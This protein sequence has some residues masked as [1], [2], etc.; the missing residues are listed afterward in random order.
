[1]SSSPDPWS[2]VRNIAGR[3]TDETRPPNRGADG[4]RAP[5]SAEPSFAEASLPKGEDAPD[6]VPA[7]DDGAISEQHLETATLQPAR[8]AEPRERQAVDVRPM[9]FVLGI[10]IAGAIIGM[11]V[12]YVLLNWGG[13]LWRH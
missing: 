2:G 9:Y 10:G 8:V 13:A 7:A 4:Q 11:F 3:D 12:A 1:M 6:G 5:I